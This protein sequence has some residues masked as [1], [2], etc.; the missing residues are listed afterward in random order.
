MFVAFNPGNPRARVV[1]KAWL[2]CDLRVMNVLITLSYKETSDL[3]IRRERSD[4]NQAGCPVSSISV[5]IFSG[6]F[7]LFSYRLLFRISVVD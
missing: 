1:L 6:L 7:S 2:G 4:F 3:E 5:I